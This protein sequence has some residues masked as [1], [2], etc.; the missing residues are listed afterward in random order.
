MQDTRN[1]NDVLDAGINIKRTRKWWL[2]KISSGGKSLE[3]D[4]RS[5]RTSN[6]TN[7]QL[8]ALVIPNTSTTVS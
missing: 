5:G 2:D 7:D 1:I 8:R 6:L 3:D 4:D